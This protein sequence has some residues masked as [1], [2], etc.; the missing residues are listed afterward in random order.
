MLDDVSFAVRDGTVLALLGENGAG[1]TTLLKLIAGLA[2]PDAGSIALFGETDPRAVDALRRTRV[3][4]SGGERG[5]YFRLTVRQNL[6]FFAALDGFR[7]RDRAERIVRACAA[8]DVTRELDTRFA[9]LSSGLRQRT[10]IARALLGDADVLLL[11]EPTRTLDPLHAAAIRAFVR[12]VLV[13]E[14]GKTVVLATNNLHEAVVLGDAASVVRD[15]RLVPLD[16]SGDALERI[17]PER[18]FTPAAAPDA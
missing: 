17:A 8:V 16:L 15:G 14:R 1:K 18:L 6:D 4:Y 7:G 2:R 3:A 5:F 13:R 12:D 10:A 11:D 9:E